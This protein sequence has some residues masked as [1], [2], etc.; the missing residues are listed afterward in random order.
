MCYQLKLSLIFRLLLAPTQ[1]KATCSNYTHVHQSVGVTE[2]GKE[3]SVQ[4]DSTQS[5]QRI[6]HITS[7]ASWQSANKPNIFHIRKLII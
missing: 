6:E 4:L 1:T 7:K 5:H 2:G 3:G